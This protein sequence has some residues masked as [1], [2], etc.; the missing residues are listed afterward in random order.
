MTRPKR[1]AGTRDSMEG[2]EYTDPQH[3]EAGRV[4]RRKDPPEGCPGFLGVAKWVKVVHGMGRAV[5]LG[6]DYADERD[7]KIWVAW[8]GRKEYSFHQSLPPKLLQPADGPAEFCPVLPP[9]PWV[10]AGE[11]TR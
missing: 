7:V 9:R 8:E 11:G 3:P 4:R 5:V 6:Y 10:P 2:L 1:W